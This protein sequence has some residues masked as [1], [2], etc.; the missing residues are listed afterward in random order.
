LVQ[1]EEATETTQ[2]VVVVRRG[3]GAVV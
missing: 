1:Q 2:A 3:V